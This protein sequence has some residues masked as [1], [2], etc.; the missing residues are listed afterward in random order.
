MPQLKYAPF[1]PVLQQKTDS[2]AVQRS[3]CAA[4]YVSVT[5][6]PSTAC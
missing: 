3:V 1:F 5:V 2:S 4:G 6:K